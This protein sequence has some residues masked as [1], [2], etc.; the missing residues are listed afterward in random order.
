MPE[1]T[2]D[3]RAV[4]SECGRHLVS[5]SDFRGGEW[6]VEVDICSNCLSTEQE[7]SHQAGYKQCEMDNDL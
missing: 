5:S 6:L 1:L 3:F 7:L 4:C 2:V